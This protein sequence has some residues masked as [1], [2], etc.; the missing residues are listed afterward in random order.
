MSTLDDIQLNLAPRQGAGQLVCA[1]V[2]LGF[3]SCEHPVPA[4]AH[5]WHRSDGGW[6]ADLL[7]PGEMV[8]VTTR[9]TTLLCAALWKAR[10]GHLRQERVH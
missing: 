5:A 10:D 9:V 1:N 2:K 6:S 3:L 4:D 7:T 8:G